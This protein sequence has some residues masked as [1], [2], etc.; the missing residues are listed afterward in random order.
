MCIAAF[1]FGLFWSFLVQDEVYF[2]KFCC[3]F[4]FTFGSEFTNYYKL[5]KSQKIDTNRDNLSFIYSITKTGLFAD[6]KRV[7]NAA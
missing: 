1:T 2:K 4:F 6:F 3:N 5:F 7:I